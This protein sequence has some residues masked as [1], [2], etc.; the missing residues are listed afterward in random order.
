MVV[1]TLRARVG[2]SCEA[3][4]G[5]EDTSERTFGSLPNAW[6]LHEPRQSRRALVLSRSSG[7]WRDS[8]KPKN[9]Y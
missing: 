9:E 2:L 6:R 3:F 1:L 8:L 5:E 4:E 7:S